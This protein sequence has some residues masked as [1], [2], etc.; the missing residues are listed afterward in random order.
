M[1]IKDRVTRLLARHLV[2]LMTTE[3]LIE[4]YRRLERRD[5]SAVPGHAAPDQNGHADRTQETA[6]DRPEGK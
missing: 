3:E 6:T 4:A 1:S 2:S 5:G